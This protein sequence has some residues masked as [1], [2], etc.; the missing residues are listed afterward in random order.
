ML[1]Y[2]AIEIFTNEEARYK[3]KPVADAVV[4]YVRDLKLAARCTIS[5]GVG[6]CYENG[7]MTTGRLEILSYNLPLHIEIVLPAAACEQVIKGL[8]VLVGDGIIAV[9]DLMVVSHKTAN[10]FFPRQLTV[11]DV[12]TK[13]PVSV[14]REQDLATAAELLLSSIFTGLP[15]VDEAGHPLGILTQGDLINRGGLPLRLGILVNTEGNDRATVMTDLKE[16]QVD[17]VMSEPALCI[18]DDQPLTEAVELMLDKGLKRLPVVNSKNILVG[19][20]SRLDIFTTVMRET[21]N[22]KSFHSQK[23]TVNNL[24][25]VRDIL[26][27]DT[28]TVTPETPLDTVLQIIDGN[29]IQCVA[30]VDEKNH[31]VGM[32]ADS[33]LL[34]FFKPDPQGLQALFARFIHPLS[35]KM[36]EKLAQTTAGQV[37]RTELIIAREDMVL[38]EAITLMTQEQL[39]RLPV[40]DSQG[41]FLGMI[42]RDSLLRTGFKSLKG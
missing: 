40:V 13:N 10:T 4:E 32:I 3:G 29:D 38:E 41:H 2:K 15:V 6:G 26:R 5:R 22:W 25:S 19:I 31:L 37:M 17:E 39:K 8:D 33:N 1:N 30:V 23:I 21:P 16:K 9:R 36:P 24:H 18:G 35:T 28:R 20:L 42:S 11:R 14:T 7:E 27:Q 34:H 12:M